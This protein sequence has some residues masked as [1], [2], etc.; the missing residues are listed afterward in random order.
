MVACI[1]SSPVSEAAVWRV[2]SQI[3]NIQSALNAAAAGDTILVADGTYTGPSNTNLN[4]AGKGILLQS[5]NGPE[6]CIIDCQQAA[7][8]F[9]FDD[10]EPDMAV[11]DGFTIKRGNTTGDQYYNRGGAILINDSRATF[12]NCI[13]QDN[14]SEAGGGGVSIIYSGRGTF[15][16]CDI[17][18]NHTNSSGGGISVD[19]GNVQMIDCRVIGNDASI[20][21]GGILSSAGSGN[22]FNVL[23][24]GNIAQLAG[25]GVF[26]TN[27][28][29]V[30]FYNC[31]IAFNLSGA[32]AGGVVT[33]DSRAEFHN[34]T[35]FSNNSQSSGNGLFA[36]GSYMPSLRNCIV[37]SNGG[38]DVGGEYSNPPASYCDIMWGGSSN[39]YPGAG[40]IDEDPLF[41]RQDK[42]YLSCTASGQSQDSPCLDAGSSAA[43]SLCKDTYLG[44][45]CMDDLSVRT[46][47]VPDTGTVDMGYHY[48]ANIPTPTPTQSVTSTPTRTPTSTP[49]PTPTT[50]LCGQG[51]Y[52]YVV[53]EEHFNTWPPAGWT[54]EINEGDCQWES[55][56]TCGLPNYAGYDGGAA[57]CSNEW[58]GTQGRYRT[59]LTSPIVDITGEP[60]AR[61][62]FMLALEHGDPADYFRLGWIDDFDNDDIL[63]LRQDHS[64]T[65]PGELIQADVA[66]L[67]DAS[68]LRFQF[69]FRSDE[70]NNYILIDRIAVKVCRSGAS[71]TPTSVPPTATFPP[72]PTWTPSPT[73]TAECNSLGCT[74]TMPSNDFATGDACSCTLIIC[75]PGPDS[76][77]TLPVFAILDVYGTYFFAPDFSSF[78]HYT[79]E[80]TPGQQIDRSVTAV[81]LANRHRRG[82]GH[83]LVCGHH[84]R[85]LFCPDRR[86]RVFRIRM[87]LEGSR[88]GCPRSRFN[89]TRIRVRSKFKVGAP[90]AL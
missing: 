79:R 15:V 33:Y 63:D 41:A 50:A 62:E 57:C 67:N 39:P 17:M 66:F 89:C 1:C 88:F 49:T 22:Y 30:N 11:V 5:E 4:F 12:L 60:S 80:I 90:T 65:G 81:R 64:P 40:N 7:R 47:L 82:I 34:C 58:C 24:E 51:Y 86:F 16:N 26:L 87:A 61:L 68:N 56:V 55:N 73:P 44:Y 19:S 3:A 31:A 2:P 76:L 21:G 9:Y 32:I 84:R 37:Y 38:Y 85:G 69:T 83:Q 78:A 72:V 43:S 45:I 35:I 70:Y 75:N 48:P 18:Y 53:F 74:I 42:Y 59:V 46:D 27:I 28:P 14:S 77:G 25:G 10:G 54:I 29:P 36:H 71:P 13:I 23:I 6:N 8:G 52:E 20:S